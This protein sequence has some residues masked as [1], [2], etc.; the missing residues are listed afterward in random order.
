MKYFEN[1]LVD[2][3]K[4]MRDYNIFILPSNEPGGDYCT[5]LGNRSALW[6]DL[7]LHQLSIS[8]INLAIE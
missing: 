3:H 8:D 6:A 1:Y 7:K 2:M 5:L 4:M